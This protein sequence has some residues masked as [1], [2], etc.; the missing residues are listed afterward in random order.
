[1]HV[2]CNILIIIRAVYQNGY[3][4]Q[5]FSFRLNGSEKPL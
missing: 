2:C 3:T 5:I 4:A 1:M